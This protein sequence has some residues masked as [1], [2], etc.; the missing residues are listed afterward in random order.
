MPPVRRASATPDEP[1]VRGASLDPSSTF[2]ASRFERYAP[3][4]ASV[5]GA[6]ADAPATGYAVAFPE[7]GRDTAL[8]DGREWAAK[9]AEKC[10]DGCGAV[11]YSGEG[12]AGSGATSGMASAR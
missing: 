3:K 11:E 9:Q 4:H 12:G 8:D 2:N 10:V 5:D 1:N 6:L 7:A